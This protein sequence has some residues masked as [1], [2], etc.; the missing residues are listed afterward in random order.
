MPENPDNPRRKSAGIGK[1]KT[2]QFRCP[3]I[4]TIPEERVQASE[5]E[6]QNNPDARKS[7]KKEC[8]HRKRENGKKPCPVN[9]QLDGVWH[10]LRVN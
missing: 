7:W 4:P 2:E 9:R 6:K 8:G 5:K 10:F 1:G 3:Q